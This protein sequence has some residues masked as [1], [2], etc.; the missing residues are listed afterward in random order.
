MREPVPWGIKLLF[1]SLTIKLTHRHGADRSK[2][3]LK[4]RERAQAGKINLGVEGK[5]RV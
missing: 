2:I 5:M 3:A 1:E 4:K